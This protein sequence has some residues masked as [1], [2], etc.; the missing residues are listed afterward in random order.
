MYGGNAMGG[1]SSYDA[2][3]PEQLR[4]KQWDGCRVVP[5]RCQISVADRSRDRGSPASESRTHRNDGNDSVAP[6][7]WSA[8]RVE[9]CCGAG[10]WKG[11]T[12]FD[13]GVS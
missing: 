10:D 2:E 5:G 3:D 8:E 13:C 9:L 11:A 7:S 4:E 12:C 6:E 1:A